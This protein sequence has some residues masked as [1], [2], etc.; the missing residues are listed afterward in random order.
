MSF[1]TLSGRSLDPHSNVT[2]DSNFPLPPSLA[3][4]CKISL[5]KAKTIFNVDL[6]DLKACALLPFD[7]VVIFCFIT[8]AELKSRITCQLYRVANFCWPTGCHLERSCTLLHSCLAREDK[9]NKCFP[10]GCN[11]T[12]DVLQKNELPQ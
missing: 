8:M 1:P 7:A 9:K 2:S 4:E 11:C 5:L 6:A 10:L 12:V 3:N